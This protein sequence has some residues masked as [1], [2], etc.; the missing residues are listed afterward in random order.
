MFYTD[1]KNIAHG[2]IQPYSE[3]N[4]KGKKHRYFNKTAKGGVSRTYSYIFCI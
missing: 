3:E 4:H 2:K 1:R